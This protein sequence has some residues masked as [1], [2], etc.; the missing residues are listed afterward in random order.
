M[1]R[2]LSYVY[3]FWFSYIF[4]K[5]NMV[6]YFLLYS[7]YYL[8]VA[9]IYWL[10]HTHTCTWTHT[11]YTYFSIIYHF[12]NSTYIIHMWEAITKT[13]K[14]NRFCTFWDL[15]SAIATFF[16]FIDFI[17]KKMIPT[18]FFFFLLT[19]S[20]NKWYLLS[21]LYFLVSSHHSTTYVYSRLSWQLVVTDNLV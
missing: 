16:I 10:Y 21:P 4:K 11:I 1:E 3:I 12:K 17:S 18:S 13:R 9:Y 8:L 15:S 20:L 19:L 2:R 14:I 7:N 6:K 5:F